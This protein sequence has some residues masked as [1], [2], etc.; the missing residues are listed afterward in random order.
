MTGI[1]SVVLRRRFEFGRALDYAQ[2]VR[3]NPDRSII[4][5]KHLVIVVLLLS[6]QT[7]GGRALAAPGDLLFKLTA[8]DP[9]PGAGFGRVVATVD[10]DILVGEPARQY[11]PID[12]PGRAYLFDGQTGKLKWT[13]NNPDPTNQDVFGHAVTGG[14]GR[15]FIST[16]GLES[17]VYGFDVKSGQLLHAI[18]DPDG[19]GDTFGT[20]ATYGNGSLLVGSPAYS[21]NLQMRSV[22][23]AYLFDGA[24]GDLQR[25]LPNPEPKATDIFGSGFGMAVFDNRAIVGAQ[26][27][28]LSDDQ[29]PDGENVGRVWVFDRTTG[30]TVF[31]LENPNPQTPLPLNL[32][33]SFGRSVAANDQIIVVGADDDDTSGINGSGTVYVFDSDT[34][35][36]RHTLFSPQLEDNGTFGSSVAVTREGNIVVGAWNVSVDGI[37]GAGHAYL[38]DGVSGSLLLDLTNPE[39]D[40][41]EGFG[42]AVAAADGRIFV[43]TGDADPNGFTNAGAAYVF[44]GIPEPNSMALAVTGLVFVIVVVRTRIKWRRTTVLS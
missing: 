22:G 12:A 43:A 14:D 2:R 38:F 6:I 32:P 16:S 5:W 29:R 36:L 37:P 31:T 26:L 15:V 39:P 44:E 41:F 11:L 17:R 10:G 24:T 7:S 8:P 27:D 4:M 30:Q 3:G 21:P 1:S 40:R 13:F 19:H 25:T 34:G 28:D 18:Y 42:W 23:R 33:D 35:A 20:G 9:Q